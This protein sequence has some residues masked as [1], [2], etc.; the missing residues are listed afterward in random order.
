M[1]DPVPRSSLSLADEGVSTN[2]GTKF[3]SFVD[4]KKFRA[5]KN[6]RRR[7]E[8]NEMSE[9]CLVSSQDN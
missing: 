4:V 1:I 8:W 7:A 9:D 3:V 2:L 6:N 5:G